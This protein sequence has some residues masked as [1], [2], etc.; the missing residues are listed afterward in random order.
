MN[1]SQIAK[2]I[3][4]W[5]GFSIG[6]MIMP[7]VLSIMM[8]KVIQVPVYVGMYIKEILFISVTMAATSL[9]DVYSLTKRGAKGII[10]TVLFVFLILTALFCVS[11]YMIVNICAVL[12]Q[13]I[14]T[15]L[16]NNAAIVFFV[17]SFIIS[18]GCQVFLA[19]GEGDE[20]E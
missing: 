14:D 6:F 9:D 13:E 4:R 17:V 7:I 19:K 20:D 5:L 2:R 1:H 16:V 12:E 3:I 8:Y 18:G 11:L 15:K 10:T